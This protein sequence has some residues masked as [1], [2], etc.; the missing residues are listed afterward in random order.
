MKSSL[1]RRFVDCAGASW[2]S[3][4][5]SASEGGVAVLGKMTQQEAEGIAQGYADLWQCV[6]QLVRVPFLHV[7]DS[8]PWADEDVRQLAQFAFHPLTQEE[9]QKVLF[10]LEPWRRR[11][12]PPPEARDPETLEAE[13]AEELRA[14]YEWRDLEMLRGAIGRVVLARMAAFDT[15]TPEASETDVMGVIDVRRWL[16]QDLSA[17]ELKLLAAATGQT[18]DA[19][20]EPVLTSDGLA[21]D[22]PF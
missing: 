1:N 14:F 17:D 21:D 15:A 11:P 8:R 4:T 6:T 16:E 5:T 19:R 10:Q 20:S 9:R 2:K 7:N 18:F 13:E 22:I 12:D 3:I